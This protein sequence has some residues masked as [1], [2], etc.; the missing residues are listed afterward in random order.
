MCSGA[1]DITSSFGQAAGT[2]MNTG[3]YDNTN[4]THHATDPTNGF[5]CFG[6]PT[7][8]G[9]APT[10]DNSLW[11]SFVG[12]GN[13]YLIETGQCD[14]ASANYIDD[15]DTQIAIYSGTCGS[16]V[17]VICNE[18]GPSATATSYPAG[19]SFRPEV[20]VT[21][22]MMID[23]FRFISGATNALSTGEFCILV[24]RMPDVTCGD[25]TVS[26]G[27]T[28][29]TATQICNG[30]AVSF[31][32]TGVASPNVGD[33]FGASWAITT[34]DLMGDI[35]NLTDP[36]QLI[37]TYTAVSPASANSVLTFTND[38]SF[39]DGGN[40]PFGTYYW[41]RIVYGMATQ[42]DPTVPVT[43][44]SDL[45]LSP[46]CTFVG[47]SQVVTVYE[48]NDPACTVSAPD[49]ITSV[50]SITNLYPVPVK[51][52]LNVSLSSVENTTVNVLVRDVLGRVTASTNFSAVAGANNIS[53]KLNNQPAGVYSVTVTDGNNVAVSK[54]VKE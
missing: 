29:A 54:F 16:L 43:F 38:L 2:V 53:L 14:P 33:F 34:I 44:L 27:T 11:F 39:I 37:A 35:A 26:A 48:P 9:T 15:G 21:Y 10:I 51:N 3:P 19:L 23:G 13:L 18:D 1:I 52:E 41:T 32:S 6:E 42:A 31:T 30:E 12:D 46:T 5:E 20:G 17:P 36:A 28:T 50:F 49:A 8:S 25:P 40:I 7:G 22:Y 4:A 24:N 45:T 47:T